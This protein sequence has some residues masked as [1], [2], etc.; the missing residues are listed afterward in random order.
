MYFK[1]ELKFYH[2]FALDKVIDALAIK[3]LILKQILT[4]YGEVKG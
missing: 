2:T 3:T 4:L 1:V